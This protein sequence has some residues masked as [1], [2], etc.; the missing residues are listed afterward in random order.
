MI[1]LQKICLLLLSLSEPLAASESDTVNERVPV[2]KAELEAHWHVD[3]ARVAD[4]MAQAVIGPT[5][6][7]ACEFSPELRHQ[8]QLCA[9]IYQAPGADSGHLCPDFRGALE[10]LERSGPDGDCASSRISLHSVEDC[11]TR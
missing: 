4:S 8:L 10:A 1:S 5:S 2:S 9:F 11:A 7:D 6:G 3:C